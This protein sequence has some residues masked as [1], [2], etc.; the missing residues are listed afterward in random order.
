MKR[1]KTT[2]KGGVKMEKSIEDF[3]RRIENIENVLAEAATGDFNEI[4][5]EKDDTLT[6]IEMGVNLL[7]VDLKEEMAKSETLIK[8]QKETLQELSTPVIQVWDNIL[9]MPII[10]LVDS[11]RAADMMDKLL[12]TVVETETKH[13]II[14]ITG[15]DVVDTKT[16][17]HFIKMVKAVKLLGSN[18]YIT[19]INPSIAQTLTQIGIDLGDIGTL[20]TLQDGLRE[21]FR[22]MGVKVTK[23]T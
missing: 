12:T 6:S 3:E 20:R 2:N 16:A 5:I 8:R 11:K 14:D 22:E 1:V 21:S 17:D 13:V 15:V 9:T 4:V 19:G 23:G 10:G 18:C 7:L